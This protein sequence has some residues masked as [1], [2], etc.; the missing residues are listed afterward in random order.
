MT[1]WDNILIHNILIH[2]LDKNKL[3]AEL[4]AAIFDSSGQALIIFIVK[5]NLFQH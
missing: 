5:R 4:L 2:N 1:V 3:L